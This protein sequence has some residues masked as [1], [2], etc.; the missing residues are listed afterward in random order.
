MLKLYAFYRFI[1]SKQIQR[2]CKVK[3]TVYKKLSLF[4]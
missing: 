1:V 3:F 4:N 2:H